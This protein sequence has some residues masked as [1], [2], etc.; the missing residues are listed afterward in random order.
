VSRC[1]RYATHLYATLHKQASSH[2]PLCVWPHTPDPVRFKRTSR[3]YSPLP[4]LQ[5]NIVSFWSF[6]WM[7]RFVGVVTSYQASATS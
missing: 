1:S 5:F 3:P 4:R 2:L 7:V 6:R